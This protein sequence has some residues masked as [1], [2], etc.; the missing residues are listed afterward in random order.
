MNELVKLL[1][2][3]PKKRWEWSAV[4]ANPNITWEYITK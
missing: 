1:E 4:S 2:A 3:F